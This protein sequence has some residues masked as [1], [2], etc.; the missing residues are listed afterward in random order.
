MRWLG[1]TVATL[2]IGVFVL[3]SGPLELAAKTHYSR[4]VSS[5]VSKRVAALH[6]WKLKDCSFDPPSISIV[7]KPAF[8]K[9]TT[10]V[11]HGI[12][13]KQG[14][15]GS[16]KCAGRKLPA[17]GVYYRSKPGYKG[18]DLIMLRLKHKSGRSAIFS[19]SI[20]VR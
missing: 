14:A 20:R 12:T 18:T 4:E 1:K 15:D 9:L 10:K 17:L 3:T 19:Y 16:T 2:G 8:G 6:S 11:V 13:V 5:G 7:K